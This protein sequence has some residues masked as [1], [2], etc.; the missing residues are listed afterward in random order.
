VLNT[1]ENAIHVLADKRETPTHEQTS[2]IDLR[3]ARLN[4]FCM[5]RDGKL[6]LACGGQ[7]SMFGAAVDGQ[8]TV[9]LVGPEPKIHVYSPQGKPLAAW[10]MDFAPQAIAQAADGAIYVAGEGRIARL[11]GDGKVLAAT[12]APHVAELPPL[13]ALPNPSAPKSEEDDAAR[14]K[15]AAEIEKVEAQSVALRDQLTALQVKLRAA[16]NDAEATAAAQKEYRE[17][18][19]E[20]AA[21]AAKLRELKTSPEVLAAQQ[22]QAALQQLNIAAIAVSDE[23]VFIACRMTKGFGFAVWRTDRKLANGKLIVEGLRGCCGQM[24]I[25][26]CGGD[27]FVA[28]NARKKVIRYDR[29]GQRLGEWGESDR[30]GV[31][32]F[33]SCCNPM[34]LAFNAAG[35]MLT[36]ESALGR[37]KRYSLDGQLLGVVGTAAVEGGCK[38][39]A[40][41]ISPDGRHVYVMDIGKQRIC[42]M[43]AIDATPE[44]SQLG[45][46]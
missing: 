27:L 1:G 42:V 12:D 35:E 9:K 21:T 4:T 39:V 5:A 13:P 34:N 24:D 40:V 31:A 15:R 38:N 28:E 45:G 19:P 8:A 32:G 11:D 20:F 23:D 41:G 14:Q 29:D 43:T 17:L 36:S 25:E 26:A 33:G 18:L 10:P 46:Q 7:R 6:L 22:R 3:D 44:V 30:V 37:V 2:A 16:G